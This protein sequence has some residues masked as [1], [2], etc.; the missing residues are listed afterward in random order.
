VIPQ[1]IRRQLPRAKLIQLK[2]WRPMP[3][4]TITTFRLANALQIH[5]WRL[6]VIVRA[7]YLESSARQLHPHLFEEP[8]S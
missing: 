1:H 4:T 7:P 5:L 6:V 8:R 3:Y 2:W